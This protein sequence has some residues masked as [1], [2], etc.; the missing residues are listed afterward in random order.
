MKNYEVEAIMRFTDKEEGLK[1]EFGEKFFCT[2]ERYKVLKSRNAVKLLGVQTSIED[3]TEEEV[4]AV[5]VAIKE[6]AEEQEK[7]VEQIIDD[8]VE[9]VVETEEIE[10]IIEK[11]VD[12]VVDEI[13]SKKKKGKRK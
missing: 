6:Q 7:K 12:N 2:E 11:T 4:Q 5:A 8:I 1:R 3:I 10:K 13:I 9:E